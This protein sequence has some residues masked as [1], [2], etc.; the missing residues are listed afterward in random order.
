MRTWLK[1]IRE[2]KGLRASAVAHMAGMDV[3][4][5]SRIENGK[6]KQLTFKVAERIAKALEFSVYEF[7]KDDK[8]GALKVRIG[9]FGFSYESL[10]EELDIAVTCLIDKVNGKRKF[11]WEEIKKLCTLLYIENPL[12]WF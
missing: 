1:E 10:A 11:K 8:F 5:Y 2:G 9:Q 7:F 12:D 4:Y 3:G 6:I